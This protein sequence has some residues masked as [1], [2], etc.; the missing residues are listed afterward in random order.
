MFCSLIICDDE[1][2]FLTH[3]KVKLFQSI[4]STCQNFEHLDLKD[5]AYGEYGR[6]ITENDS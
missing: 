4:Y 3:K 2:H 1:I 6:L 5:K